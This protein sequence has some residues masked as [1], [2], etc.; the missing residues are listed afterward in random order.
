MMSWTVKLNGREARQPVR[1]LVIAALLLLVVAAVV[2]EV[3]GAVVV[4]GN[5]L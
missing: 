1:G 4:I 3:V 5:I 2:F